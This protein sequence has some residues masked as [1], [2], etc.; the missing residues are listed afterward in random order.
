[1]SA[2]AGTF[3]K[4]PRFSKQPALAADALPPEPEIHGGS[5]A[6]FRLQQVDAVAVAGEQ[7]GPAVRQGIGERLLLRR[8]DRAV[9]A[10]EQQDTGV[11]PRQ[12]RHGINALETVVH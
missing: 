6:A 11:Y 12:Q 10:T 9:V 1:M 5:G 2:G 3:S 4:R 8:G 7:L